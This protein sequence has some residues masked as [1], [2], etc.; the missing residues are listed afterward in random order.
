M[1]ILIDRVYAVGTTFFTISAMGAKMFVISKINFIGK[2]FGVMT[3]FTSKWTAF[4]KYGCS[5]P[6]PVVDGK[7]FDFKDSRFHILHTNNISLL[8]KQSGII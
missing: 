1:P 4:K 7:M 6:V 5:Y 8:G 3:P 2:P